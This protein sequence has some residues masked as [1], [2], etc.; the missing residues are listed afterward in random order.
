MRF[1]RV[2][3]SVI[4]IVAA[5]AVAGGVA[6]AAI[7]DANGN[8]HGCYQK[9]SGALRLIAA[10]QRCRRSERGIDWSQAGQPGP[11]GPRG[12][13]GPVGPPGPQGVPGLVKLTTVEAT[14][15]IDNGL[16]AAN[17]ACPNGE[18]ATGGGYWLGHEA[19]HVTQSRPLISA[20]QTPVGWQVIV[21][22]DRGKG[23]VVVYVTCAKSS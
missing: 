6:Y 5:S 17:V 13:A 11:S 21:A 12:P 14:T 3:R 16:Q 19:N 10:D 18:V 22:N 4:G 20:N 15:T 23:F 1:P 9:N 7:P 2:H 8:I